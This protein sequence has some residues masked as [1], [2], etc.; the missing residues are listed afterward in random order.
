MGEGG[1]YEQH[2]V[3]VCDGQQ[4]LISVDMYNLDTSYC[5]AQVQLH[6]G[7]GTGEAAG[8]WWLPGDR[9]N[10]GDSRD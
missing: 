1:G 9:A 3:R 7:H 8:D 10:L 4:R 2:A 6:P 5:P